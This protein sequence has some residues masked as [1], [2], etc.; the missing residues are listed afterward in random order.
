MRRLVGG[1]MLVVGVGLLAALRVGCDPSKGNDGGIMTVRKGS[2]EQEKENRTVEPVTPEEAK[3]AK[4]QIELAIR[5]HGGDNLARVQRAMVLEQKGITD[6]NGQISPTTRKWQVALPDRV[7]LSAAVVGQSEFDVGLTSAGAWLR[8][9]TGTGE[10]S[11]EYLSDMRADL[12]V[13]Q[14][15]ALRP[16]RDGEFVLKPLP[17]M[18]VRGEPAKGVKVM[19]KDQIQVELYFDAKTNLLSRVF[20]RTKLGGNLIGKE[21]LLMKYKQIEGVQMPNHWLEIHDGRRVMEFE[22]SEYRFP[23]EIPSAV[24]A[25]PG[26]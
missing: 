11:P 16:L 9:A 6:L 13:F 5:A 20:L 1:V 3:Q 17:D 8:T 21:V 26:N 24:F 18:P 4:N 10:L 15:L 7:Y 25:K 2:T 14:M 22:D 12:Y 19:C 23:P